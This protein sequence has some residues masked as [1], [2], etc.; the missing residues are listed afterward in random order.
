ML[1]PM[2][3]LTE[4]QIERLQRTTEELLEVVGFQV[5]NAELRRRARA[6]GAK[7]EDGS[8]R[9]HL[10]APLLRELLAQVPP[11]YS[12]IQLD[13]TEHVIGAGERHILPIVTDP[14][15]IDYQTQKPRRPCLDDVR[16]HTRLAQII[17]QT[18]AMSL[19]D[20]PVTD[21]PGPASSLRAREEYVQTHGKHFYAMPSSTADLRIWLDLGKILAQ[22]CGVPLSELMTVA[23]GVVSPLTLAEANAEHLL[24]A[25]EHQLPVVPTVCPSAGMTAPYSLASALLQAN[26]EVLFVAALTQIVRPGN[27]F[28]YSMG[29][30]T[31]DMATGGDRYYTLDK[32]L[33]KIA[34]VQMGR[35]Y[36]LPTSAE[37][38]GT[39]NPRYDL[40]SGAEGVLFM[41]S[42]CASG[43]S[44]LAGLGSCYN[45]L[46]MSAEMM[47]IQTAWLDVAEFLARGISTDELRLGLDSLKKAGP[48]GSF[49]MD[50]L[51]LQ[52]M[53]GGEFFQSRLF[54]TSAETGAG[55]SMLERAHEQ[56][57]ELIASYRCPV[58]HKVREDIQRYFGNL[59]VKLAA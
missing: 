30:S 53:R 32:V 24:L 43:A 25:C 59:Y 34:G 45:A 56:A 18:V 8:D 52:F 5:T 3:A 19:M 55:K 7:L 44:L 1:E 48:G 29:L 16:R 22:G 38:G 23:V 50:D 28:L 46:G 21:A 49:L 27:P 13:G 58:P 37:C 11:V 10:P 40:Q 54:D 39:L 20:F 42:A 35:S 9:L 51:T 15:I 17:P 41:L 14:W 36:H 33:W 47:M 57:E 31:T 12:V 2:K 6:A 26:A 4:N